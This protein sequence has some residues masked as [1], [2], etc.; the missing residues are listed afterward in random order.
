MSPEAKEVSWKG[1]VKGWAR[2]KEVELLVDLPY[3]HLLSPSYIRTMVSP[4]TPQ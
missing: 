4:P 1:E 3:T 2:G